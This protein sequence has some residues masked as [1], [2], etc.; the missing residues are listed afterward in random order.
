LGLALLARRRGDPQAAT[1]YEQR[2]QRAH[3]RRTRA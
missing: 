1:R 2:S 3:A